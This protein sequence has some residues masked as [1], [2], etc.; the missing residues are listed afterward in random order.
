MCTWN[1]W[2]GKGAKY[3]VRIGGY[4]LMTNHVHVTSTLAAEVCYIF[5]KC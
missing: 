5:M 4:C 2:V 1:R 3:G